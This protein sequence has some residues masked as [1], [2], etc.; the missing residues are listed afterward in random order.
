MAKN[1]SGAESRLLNTWSVVQ[2]KL[3]NNTSCYVARDRATCHV[4]YNTKVVNHWNNSPVYEFTHHLL[5]V[6]RRN[7]Q[8]N[9]IL[10]CLN[11]KHETLLFLEQWNLFCMIY[12][13]STQSIV[14]LIDI[15]NYSSKTYLHSCC[16]DMHCIRLFSWAKRAHNTLWHTD[17]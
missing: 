14:L 3:N 1:F 6:H 15:N 12:T 9:T 16:N 11:H 13:S 2:P 5:R 4:T 8:F 17:F 10:L 7:F